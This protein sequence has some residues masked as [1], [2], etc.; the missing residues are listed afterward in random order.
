MGGQGFQPSQTFSPVPAFDAQLAGLAI[1]VALAQANE[2]QD[3]NVEPLD[4]L[5]QTA[6]SVFNLPGDWPIHWIL[7]RAAFVVI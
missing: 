1:G 5:L 2:P 4:H 3:V 6:G 7:P